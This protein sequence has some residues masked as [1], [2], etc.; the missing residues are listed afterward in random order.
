MGV[1]DNPESVVFLRVSEVCRRV[2]LAR[3]T[4]YA[5]MA[6]GAFPR[7]VYPAKRAPRWRSDEISAWI[8]K[9]TAERTVA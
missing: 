4:V 9:L 6:Q 8:A 1:L 5:R 7:P 3:G 2:G